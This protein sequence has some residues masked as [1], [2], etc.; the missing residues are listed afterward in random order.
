MLRILFFY[1][2]WCEPCKPV[3]EILND[4]NNNY[5][6]DLEL[7]DVEMMPDI[8]DKYNVN[9]YPTVIVLKSDKKV[10]SICGYRSPEVYYN[11]VEV[12]T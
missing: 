11:L 12:E 6:I 10:K 3:L 7:I 2:E 8:A 5:K 1:T 9:A 4:I